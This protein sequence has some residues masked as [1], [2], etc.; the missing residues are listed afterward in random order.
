MVQRVPLVLQLDYHKTLYVPKVLAQDCY[1][2]KRLAIRNFGV[3]DGDRKLMHCFICPET[4]SGEG[5]DEVISFLDNLLNNGHQ[6]Y[7]HLILYAD[8]YLILYAVQR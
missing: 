4:V 6:D 3:Y 5:P 7:K 1:F 8:L 2:R